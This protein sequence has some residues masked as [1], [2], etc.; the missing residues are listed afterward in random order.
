M[1]LLM[2]FILS[3]IAY[4]LAFITTEAATT[5]LG[6]IDQIFIDVTTLEGEIQLHINWNDTI[7]ED[8]NYN[9]FVKPTNISDCLPTSCH[10]MSISKATKQAVLPNEVSPLLDIKECVILPGCSYDVKVESSNGKI[11][12][13]KHIDIPYCVNDVCSCQH[14]SVWPKINITS[15]ITENNTVEASWTIW[16]PMDKNTSS[17]FEEFQLDKIYISISQ[18]TNPSLTWGG[19]HIFVEE[20]M[21]GITESAISMAFDSIEGKALF[22]TSEQLNPNSLYQ[23]RAH[24]IDKQNCTG[25][26][27]HFIIKM[28]QHVSGLKGIDNH[29]NMKVGIIIVCFL[30]ICSLT[31]MLMVC[32]RR[33]STKSCKNVPRVMFSHYGKNFTPE[34][35]EDNILYVDKDVVDAQYNGLADIFEVPHSAVCIG[36]E[37]GVGAFGRVFKATARNL[38]RMRGTTIVAV[39]QLKTNPTSEEIQEFLTEINMLKEVGR[40]H[41]IVSFL[42]CCTIRAPYMMIMEYVGRGDLLDYLRT[43]RNRVS[44]KQL[45]QKYSEG[46]NDKINENMSKQVKYIELKRTSTSHSQQSFVSDEAE[47]NLRPSVTETMYTTL[48]EKYKSMNDEE[49]FTFEYI[50]DHAELHNFALQIAKGMQ[51]LEEQQITHRDLAARNV[52]VDDRKTLKISDFG[53]SR[54]GIYTNTKTRKLPLRWLS[55]EAI[56]DNLYSSK[57]DVWAFG[58]VLWEIGTLGASPYPTLSNNELIPFLLSGQRLEKPEICS[59]KVYELM[60]HCW[61]EDPIIRPSFSDIYAE[62]Q[63]KTIYVDISSIS[64]DYVFPP[65]QD[66]I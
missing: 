65:I 56:R 8:W 5:S 36:Q 1:V 29:L 48:S 16:I 38:L 61:H 22:Q 12:K 47:V 28:P 27:E 43:V 7:V 58:V 19:K 23:I 54:H 50:L 42:G 66:N 62:L 11:F 44:L 13:T 57:S 2:S 39:K 46:H 18:Q 24:L 21:Y 31:L 64:D 17:L 33:R 55:I 10:Q 63:P 37:I 20:K 35:M 3:I 4:V 45:N 51:F 32:I 30:S 34:T 59:D 53:L 6:F 9:V 15:K 60:L 14:I 49:E 52:L 25:P 41:N 26:I 40:H